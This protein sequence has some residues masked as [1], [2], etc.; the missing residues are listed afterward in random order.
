MINLKEKSFELIKHLNSEEIIELNGLD[1]LN[2]QTFEEDVLLLRQK[3]QETYPKTKL[4]R[5]MK[6]AHFA[7]GFSDE[8]LKRIAFILTDEIEQYLTVNGFLNHDV[9][10]NYFNDKITSTGFTISPVSLV[11]VMLESLFLSRKSK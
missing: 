1:A 5:M 6:I 10:V 11:G 9:L 4:K 2:E 7:N 3:L 8:N